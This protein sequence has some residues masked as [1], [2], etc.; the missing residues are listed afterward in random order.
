MLGAVV[1]SLLALLVVI[2]TVIAHL[3]KP[4]LITYLKE[5]VHKTSDRLYTLE[6]DRLGLDLIRGR[7][8]ITGLHLVP[9]TLRYDSLRAGGGGPSL[10][11]D[12]QSDDLYIGG[13]RLYRLWRQKKLDIDEVS[14]EKPQVRL[15]KHVLPKDTVSKPFSFDPYRMIAPALRSLKVGEIRVADGKLGYYRKGA[16]R[17][18]ALDFNRFDLEVDGLYIDSLSASDTTRAFYS[19]DLR[20]NFRDF[21]F[22]LPDSLYN[23]HLGAVGLSSRES[24]LSIESLWLEPRHK[25]MEFHT[26]AGAETDHIQLKIGSITASGFD[27]RSFLRNEQLIARQISIEN[28]SLT[29]FLYNFKID[30]RPYQQL[31][32]L[33]LKKAGLTLDIREL[34]I[35]NSEAVY[36]ERMAGNSETGEVTFKRLNGTISNITNVPGQIA[37]DPVIRAD[38]SAYLMDVG[39]MQVGFRFHLDRE[40]GYFT[41]NGS[42]GRM[43]LEAVNP[44]LEAAARLK[45][46]RGTMQK[47]LFSFEADSTRSKGSMKFYYNNLNVEL[48][49]NENAETNMKV[50]S[51]LT[52]LLL[53]YSN[54]PSPNEALRTGAIAFTRLKNKSIFNYLW[55]SL[56]S[57]FKSSVGI[58]REK[59][60][61]LRNMAEMFKDRKQRREQRRQERRERREERRNN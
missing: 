32:H 45:L 55:K 26:I 6:F 31:P 59:E 27:M 11:Y 19:D 7:V 17:T 30:D 48:L 44:M 40:D 5:T 56:L 52:N 58:T 18:L 36:R 39:E 16:L 37:K 41:V 10:L 49:G 53:L 51:T 2:N 24:S 1:V 33:V 8:H 20:L 12:L 60:T 29:D 34:L 38:V 43:P 15:I 46:K 47:L 4:R 57:G 21:R 61:Q 50:A 35:R 25:E 54:N 22:Q 3:V 42:I 9:D 14:I 13:V 28:A 23:L